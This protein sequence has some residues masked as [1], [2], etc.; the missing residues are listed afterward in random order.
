M[1]LLAFDCSTQQ[2]HLGVR[3]GVGPDVLLRLEGGAAA[4]R[5]LVS[6]ALAALAQAGVP[7]QEL[8]AIAFG[9]GPGAFTGLRAACAVAQGLG[10]GASKPLVAVPTLHAVA[11]QARQAGL[12]GIAVV[13]MDARM[14]QIYAQ[15]FELDD[16]YSIEFCYEKRSYL[17]SFGAENPLFSPEDLLLFLEQI[18]YATGQA[19]AV[20]GDAPH[21]H[22]GLLSAHPAAHAAEPS[23]AALLALAAERVARGQTVSPQDAMPIYVRDNVAQTMAQRLAASQ[24]ARSAA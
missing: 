24:L 11:E 3:S 8:D 17:R 14:G 18:Q 6:A 4:S 15:A 19:V 12:R 23:A 1:K 21:A 9:A 10:F 22:A 20:V 5:T 7:L 13:A 2:L 16:Q